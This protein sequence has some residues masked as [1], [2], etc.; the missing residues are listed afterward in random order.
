MI[1]V[2]V[3]CVCV[4]QMNKR[5]ITKSVKGVIY[6]FGHNKK[7]RQPELSISFSAHVEKKKVLEIFFLDSIYFTSTVYALCVVSLRTLT[8]QINTSDISK[9]ILTLA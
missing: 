7:K 4:P 9:Q 1:N 8:I 3:V 2:N 6:Y 5:K